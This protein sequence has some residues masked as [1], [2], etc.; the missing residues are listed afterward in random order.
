MQ[1][2]RSHVAIERFE[3]FHA[4]RKVPWLL[5]DSRYPLGCSMQ[6]GRS[7]IRF[8]VAIVRFQIPF[9]RVYAAKKVPCG[10][11]KVP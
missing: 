2:E 8:H 9:G 1:L 11:W 5:E 3:R 4:A 6:L 10:Y 7:H